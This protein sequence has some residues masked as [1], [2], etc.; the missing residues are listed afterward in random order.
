V[1]AR[2]KSEHTY[3]SLCLATFLCVPV[4]RFSINVAYTWVP[5]EPS[6]CMAI[7]P[8]VVCLSQGTKFVVALLL[9]IPW[10]VGV[11]VVPTGVVRS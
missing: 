7:F 2:G 9:I 1:T 5:A 10:E 8:L 4:V 3:H 11:N 6:G